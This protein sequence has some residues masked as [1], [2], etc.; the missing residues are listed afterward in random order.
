MRVERSERLARLALYTIEGSVC[1]YDRRSNNRRHTGNC[2]TRFIRHNPTPTWDNALGR[3]SFSST[4]DAVAQRQDIRG[5]CGSAGG[6]LGINAR[7][8]PNLFPA[9]AR[10]CDRRLSCFRRPSGKRPLEGHVAFTLRTML[11]RQRYSE[12]HPKFATALSWLGNTFQNQGRYAEAASLPCPNFVRR[13]RG[14]QRVPAADHQLAS[15]VRIRMEMTRPQ[16]YH[17]RS[18]PRFSAFSV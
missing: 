16:S 18:A 1:S 17:E 10:L 14:S 15:V 8:R 6:R 5:A 2:A 13:K 4:P 7:G 11:V 3:R 9:F 12:S